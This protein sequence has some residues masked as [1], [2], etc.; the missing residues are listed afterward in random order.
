MP[1]MRYLPW[2]FALQTAAVPAAQIAGFVRDAAGNRPIAGA[3]ITSGQTVTRSAPDGSFHIS[4]NTTELKARAIGYDRQSILA[5]QTAQTVNFTLHRITPKAL[6]LTVYGVGAAQFRDNALRLIETTELNALVI[7]LKGD[8]GIVPWPA[9]NR[10]AQEAGARRLTSIKDLPDFAAR[11]HARGIYLIG[12]IVVFKDNPLA[13]C[14]PDLAVKTAGGA[15]WHDHE[16]LA[17]VDPFKQEVRDYN[18]ALAEEAAQA[19]FDE[20]QF[21]YVR[22]PD[23]PGLRFSEESTAESRERALAL[24][25]TQ[26]RSRLARYNVF[27]AADVFGYVCWNLNDTGIGQQIEKLAPLLDYASPMLY[28]SGFQFGIPGFLN[29]VAHPFEIVKFSLDRAR[30]RTE[31]PPARFRPWLQAFHDYA[32]DH[33]VFGAAQ[34]R[35]QIRA[36]EQFGSDG[37]ML[38]NARNLYSDAGLQQKH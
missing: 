13:L 10:L 3:T 19:G 32:F 38:W 2:L 11:M 1:L 28:P 18:L 9:K 37:W 23:A 24:L 21:D 16:K 36:A 25:L 15:I 29:P 30:Q 8:A 27:L 5:L 22:F 33:R 31:L 35:D 20:I 6:Y 4:G 26:A 14:R 7:D 34:L 12:R 17:W